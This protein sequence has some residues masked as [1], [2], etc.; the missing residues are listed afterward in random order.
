MTPNPGVV[1]DRVQHYK[2]NSLYM[3]PTGVRVVKKE[4][5]EGDWIK[6]KRH[7]FGALHVKG[8]GIYHGNFVENLKHGLGEF[9]YDSGEIYYGEFKQDLFDGKG[10]YTFK[11]GS[12][13]VGNYKL[14]R[15]NGG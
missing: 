13:F 3:A 2:V 12:K 14:G 6:G 11:D 9:K 5:Y 4:D 10:E 1:W 7:G 8:S 15:R